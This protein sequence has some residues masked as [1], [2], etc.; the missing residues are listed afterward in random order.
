MGGICG[1]HG[2]GESYVQ[3]L[4]GGPKVRDQRED[5]DVSGWIKLN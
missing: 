1:T 3:G 5:L 4:I 2:G